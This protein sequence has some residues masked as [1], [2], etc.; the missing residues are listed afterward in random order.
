MGIS[1]ETF[2]LEKTTLHTTAE[3]YAKDL[4]ATE[5]HL[6]SINQF[7]LFNLSIGLETA[8]TEEVLRELL[9]CLV[10]EVLAV[11]VH[12]MKLAYA[13]KDWEKIQ[14]LAHKIKGGAVYV[15]TIRLKM[16]CQYLERY[17]KTGQS[18]LLEPLYHQ[19]LTVI[20]ETIAAVE[21]SQLTVA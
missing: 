13:E 9:A 17:W 11:E 6:F 3:V 19:A 20:H 10:N 18:E 15:G 21:K 7:A 2:T 12:K 1:L 14:Q 8:G 4:P 16:A 5:A